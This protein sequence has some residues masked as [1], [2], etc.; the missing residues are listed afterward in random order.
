MKKARLAVCFSVLAIVL[1]VTTVAWASPLVVQPIDNDG[2]TPASLVDTLVGNGVNPSGVTYQGADT[3]S[4]EF[5]GGADVVGFGSGI[6]LTSGSATNVIG[7]NQSDGETTINGTPGD[8]DLTALAGSSTLD[9]AVLEFNFTPTATPIFFNFVF[10]SEE[11]NEFVYEGF[12]DVF[13]FFVNGQNC[14]LVP[15]TSQPV[16]VDNIN[17]GHPY[18]DSNDSHPEFFRNNDLQDGGPT[19]DTEM[20]GLTT[21]LTCRANVNAG[22]SNHVKLAIADTGD[23]QLDSAVFLQ[24]NSFS[25][26][27][28]TGV[29]SGKVVND[30]NGNTVDDSEAGLSGAVV[31]LYADNTDGG[32]EGQFD[33]DGVDPQVG[34]NFTTGGDG[35]W[36]FVNLDPGTYWA[37]ETDPAGYVSTNS[38]A[39]TYAAEET[40][41]RIRVDLPTENS[42]T[43]NKFLDVQASDNTQDFAAE[44]CPNTGCTIST[45]SGAPGATSTDKTVSTL[46]VPSGVDPQTITLRE[47]TS[48]TFCG[49]T[50]CQGQ[51]LEIRSSADPNTFSGVDDPTD[52]VVLT[53]VFDKT[54][55]QGS[56]V[57]INKG[58]TT[59]V[60][61]N[62][63]TT[64]IAIPG[65]CVSE[66]NILVAG[67]D[68]AFIILFTEGDPIIG[69]R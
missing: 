46:D 64:G 19:I 32:T 22:G 28:P 35:T 36:A 58:G 66:K 60:M 24:A 21:V 2:V 57:Y 29:I 31:N 18:G 5:S 50:A 49:G 67:G 33:G 1:Q 17:G 4:G 48:L 40:V 8:A 68:R 53:M 42:S 9:A 20:D 25:T 30:A 63:T 10:A 51:I 47:S 6:L 39:G 54:V 55:K 38:I 7:P 34:G 13:G 15:N 12:N 52:P 65:P 16:S 69:K 56:K 11:Y 41:N 3:A 23:A 37:V 27:P 45:D 59:T 62:C 61:R 44:F 26:I 14:A 43:G